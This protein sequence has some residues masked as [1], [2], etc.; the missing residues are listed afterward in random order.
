MQE[1]FDPIDEHW[2][3]YR[4]RRDVALSADARQPLR[5]PELLRRSPLVVPPMRT[6][7]DATLVAAY[8]SLLAR[9][10]PPGFLI[11]D[12]RELLHVFG[13]GDKFLRIKPG[14]STSDVFD[15]V[16]EDLKASVPSSTRRP[17]ATFGCRCKP[18]MMRP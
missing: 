6:V 12:R 2:K 5:P 8:D 3:I 4:K 11:S 1:E 15:L 7:A 13:D 17:A 16:H 10:M 18:K 9:Y 14:R